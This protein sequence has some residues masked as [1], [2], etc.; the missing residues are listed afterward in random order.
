MSGALTGGA[1]LRGLAAPLPALFPRAV[2]LLL[3]LVLQLPAP[4]LAAESFAEQ[5]PL[6]GVGQDIGLELTGSSQ[7]RVLLFKV[8]D[9][10]HYAVADGEQTLSA[11]KVLDA[12][13]ARALVIRFS[14][15]LGQQ[16]IRSEFRKSLERNAQPD[17]LEAAH[18]SVEAFIARIDRDADKGDELAFYWLPGGELR[19]YFNGELSFEVQDAAFA[20]SLWSIW[21]GEHPACDKDELLLRLTGVG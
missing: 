9:I 4:A 12:G 7:R 11:D 21:F 18:G 13:P 14:R 6:P 3:L 2:L 5:L 16:Q 10:A 1:L 15:T 20:R 8:Y 19:A 17:W